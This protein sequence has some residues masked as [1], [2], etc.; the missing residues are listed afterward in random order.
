MM[1]SV[2]RGE[3]L[4]VG[5]HVYLFGSQGAW[6]PNPFQPDINSSLPSILLHRFLPGGL[7]QT[8]HVRQVALS[9]VVR[10]DMYDMLRTLRGAEED[11]R[12]Q[13]V[14]R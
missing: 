9:G 12:Q 4:P 14:G 5:L 6:S 8:D 7:I 1:I 11:G 10:V 3:P 13:R 2:M